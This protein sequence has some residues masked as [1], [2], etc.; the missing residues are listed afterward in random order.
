MKNHTLCIS[1]NG[2]MIFPYSLDFIFQ[3]FLLL[4]KYKNEV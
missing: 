2:N 3:M 1:Q 4:F